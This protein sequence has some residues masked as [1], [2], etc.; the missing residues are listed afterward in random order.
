IDY[1]TPPPPP[2]P[3]VRFHYTRMTSLLVLGMIH[4]YLIW[5][6]D[7]LVLYAVCG[8]LVFLFRKLK[9][10]VLLWSAAG[11]FVLSGL[12]TLGLG[13]GMYLAAEFGDESIDELMLITPALI[14]DEVAAHRGSY[15][16]Q[17]MWRLTTMPGMQVFMVI[18]WGPRVVGLMLVGMA[19]LQLGLFDARTPV[20][21]FLPLLA[22]G[23]GVG[24]PLSLID[25]VT[26]L[27]NGE[28]T[29]FMFSAAMQWN[30]WGSAFLALAYVPVIMFACKAVGALLVPLAAVGRMA[31]TNYLAQSLIATAFFYTG[32]RFQ[33][34][35]RW[36]L[37]WFVL[38]VWVVQLVWS[39]L[40]LTR[41]RFGPAEWL[42]RSINY[43]KPQPLLRAPRQ[44]ATLPA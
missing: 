30:Y 9:P 24:V 44:P 18:M 25:A 23:L 39:P 41:F 32:G 22:I 4:A 5:F 1:A 34:W 6:G 21:K 16:D 17:T 36:E 2:S 37:A 13:G 43:A 12:L 40:W 31:L 3:A 15:F 11:F 7:I 19:L 27:R 33:A 14:A 28:D 35:E 42:W 29:L 20:Q 8:A 10:N 38:A 26:A